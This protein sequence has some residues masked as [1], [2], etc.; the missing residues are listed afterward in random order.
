MAKPLKKKSRKRQSNLPTTWRTGDRETL[1]LKE[2]DISHLINVF[3]FIKRKAYEEYCHF[4]ESHTMSVDKFCSQ[5]YPVYEAI[6]QEIANR[7]RAMPASSIERKFW[8]SKFSRD[9][10]ASTGYG[11]EK[12][13]PESEQIDA[14]WD[15]F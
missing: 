10:K 11:P 12:S 1:K 8:H 9:G 4:P 15:H 3:H 7:L 2:M 14:D 6:R 5:V 13:F